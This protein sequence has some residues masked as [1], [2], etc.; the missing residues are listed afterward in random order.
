MKWEGKG[1]V[2]LFEENNEKRKKQEIVKAVSQSPH[3][4]TNQLWLDIRELA[5]SKGG[6]PKI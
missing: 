5:T 3:K 1:L 6:K 2:K 4:G